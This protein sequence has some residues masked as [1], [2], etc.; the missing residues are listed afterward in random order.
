MEIG[1]GSQDKRLGFLLITYEGFQATW[2]LGIAAHVKQLRS[3][4]GKV[5]KHMSVTTLTVH[6]FR[7]T[8]SCHIWH[9]TA[10]KSVFVQVRADSVPLS[11]A[12]GSPDTSAL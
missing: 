6:L 4:V 2:V 9:L 12:S 8:V 1:E 11:V 3:T 10:C 7:K 5:R